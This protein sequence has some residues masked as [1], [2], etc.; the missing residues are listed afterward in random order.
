MESG[1]NSAR[2][3]YDGAHRFLQAWQ[4]QTPGASR[5]Q[6][7]P[8][9]AESLE[10]IRDRHN[11]LSFAAPGGGDD[12]ETLDKDERNQVLNTLRSLPAN[13]S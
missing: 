6:L 3:F 4:E 1:S 2:E 11:Y 10:Q 7:S 9:L 5:T 8:E 12:S 13:A